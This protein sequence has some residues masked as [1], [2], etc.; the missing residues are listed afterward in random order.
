M[1]PFSCLWSEGVVATVRPQLPG[2][3]DVDV[4]IVGAGYTGLWTAWHLRQLDP[5][6]RIAVIE[7]AHVGFGASG[8]NGGWVQTALPSTL[9]EIAARHSTDTAMLVHRTMVETVASIGAFAAVHAPEASF[10]HAGQ[11]QVARTAAQVKRQRAH[12][13]DH[14]RVGLTEHD[15]RWLEPAEVDERIGIAGRLGGHFTPHCAV[16]QPR[17]LVEG[18]ARACE[19]VGVRIFERTRAVSIAP[20]R[21]QTD[22]GAVRAAFVV[23]AVEGFT[24]DLAGHHRD[25]VPVFSL[26]IATEPLSSEQWRQLGWN[27]RFTL[28]DGRRMVIYA[29][30]T[31]DGRIAFGGRGAPYRFGSKTDDVFADNLGTHKMLHSTLVAL[32]PVLSDVAITHRWGGP[33]GVP[34]DWTA[35]VQLDRGTGLAWAGGYVGDGV[36]A[37]HLAGETLAELIVGHDTD[38]TRLPWVGHRSRRWE[39]EPL[40]SVGIRGAARLTRMIDAAEEVG[41]HP[42]LRAALLDRLL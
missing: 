2:D 15:L 28:S 24:P 32:F 22:C 10:V 23:R 26:M 41:S 18:L 33:L 30:R 9:V 6:I 34:R 42:R 1:P 27:E 12:V 3:I 29:Q 38:R 7:G 17:Q 36:G 20:Q 8:R 14:H 37:A 31:A 5:G 25:L 4:C 13:A 21:V 19:S 11:L 35:G 39:P 16:V 40:R